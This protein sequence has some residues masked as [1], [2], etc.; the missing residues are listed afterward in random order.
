MDNHHTICWACKN[1]GKGDQRT[2]EN[3]SMDDLLNGAACSAFPMGIP[4][5]IWLNLYDHRKPLRDEKILFEMQD[6]P[7]LENDARL[8]LLDYERTVAIFN[9][10]GGVPKLDSGNAR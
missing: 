6:D 8:S 3:T 1:L 2:E 7:Y 4:K 10:A 5:E 9:D